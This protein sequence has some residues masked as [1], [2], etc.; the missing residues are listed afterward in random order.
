MHFDVA[1][2]VVLVEQGADRLLGKRQAR[3]ARYAGGI[4]HAARDVENDQQVGI[5]LHGCYRAIRGH[6]FWHVINDVDDE[7]AGGGVAQ[8]IGGFVGETF[9]QAVRPVVRVRRS[10][11]C[12]SQ[13]VGVGAVGVELDLPVSAGGAANQGVSERAAAA[14]DRTDQR[15]AGGFAGIAR[16]AAG[17]RAGR[18]I[19]AA[20]AQVQGLFVNGHVLI[21][22]GDE[23]AVGDVD[24]DGRGAFVAVTVADAVGE[25]VGGAR[26]A[27]RVR[28][29]VVNGI[30]RRIK[31]QVTVGA[32]DVAVEPT[33]GRSGGVAAGAHADHIGRA[34]GAVDVVAQY[35][36]VDRTTLRHRA[37][38]GFGG[39]QIID[40]VDVDLTA[41]GTA[42]GVGRHH[43]EILGD[44]VGT[45]GVRVGFVIDQGVAVADHASGRV[46]TGDGERAAQRRD[47]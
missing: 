10:F 3:K 34:I 7:G 22:R 12:R 45:V 23:F 4:G 33:D 18:Q 28:V 20:F 24:G 39:R 14:G 8:R 27:H 29:A 47:G 25:R 35:A 44:A 46:V 11:G 37:G 42:I 30:A 16:L 19:L 13:R 17:D 26:W 15:A 9:A 6:G 5:D 36:D 1:Q 41:G 2:I 21:D 43:V 38:V 31:G 32:V 40:D